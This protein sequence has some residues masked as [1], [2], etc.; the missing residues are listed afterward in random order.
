MLTCFR[1]SYATADRRMADLPAVRKQ[2]GTG[3]DVSALHV[4]VT[5]QSSHRGPGHRSTDSVPE[6]YLGHVAVNRLDYWQHVQ[7]MLQ[8]FWRRWH[9]PSTSHKMECEKQE[10]WPWRYGDH[11]GFEYTPRHLESWTD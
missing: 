6:G 4:A 7:S 9:H 10:N 11:Q 2:R 1:Q 3:R 5:Q 8:G